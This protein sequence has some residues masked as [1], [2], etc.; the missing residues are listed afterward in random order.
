MTRPNH[1]EASWPGL[2]AAAFAL[3]IVNLWP[4]ALRADP[5]DVFP[6][7]DL[8]TGLAASS[9]S[10]PEEF[11]PLDGS[12]VFV[13][14]DIAHGTELWITDGTAPGTVLLKDIYPGFR[15]SMASDLTAF[16][17][18]VYFSAWDPSFGIELWSTDG[19]SEGTQIVADLWPGALGFSYPRDLTVAGD[20]LF[21]TATTEATGLEL[22]KLSSGGVPEL[23]ID[24]RPGEE[25]SNAK[26]LIAAGSL[27]AFSAFTPATGWELVVSDGTAIGTEIYD[28]EP[29]MASSQP[30]P[31]GADDDQLIFFSAETPA[32]GRELWRLVPG[33]GFLCR[34]MDGVTGTGSSNPKYAVMLDNTLF[35]AADSDG[36]PGIWRSGG[37][38]EATLI[39][40]LDAR[41]LIVAW[42]EVLFEVDGDLWK[43]NGTLAGTEMLASPDIDLIRNGS[44][45]N[46]VAFQP[47]AGE[48]WF[49][50]A[51][52]VWKTDG[53]AAN[54]QLRFS[55][56][57]CSSV[58]WFQVGADGLYLSRDDGFVD[59][60]PWR[61]KTS[62]FSLLADINRNI[63]HSQPRE[64]TV[65]EEQI[66]FTA[67]TDAA[68]RELLAWDGVAA[69][70]WVLE[71]LQPGTN[72]STPQDLM[73]AGDR[74]FYTANDPIVGSEL[75]ILEEPFLASSL[76]VD[77]DSGQPRPLGVL[78]G[79]LFFVADDDDNVDQLWTTP[80]TGATQ[81]S[82]FPPGSS[83]GVTRFVPA[84]VSNGEIYFTADDGVHGQE[85]WRS[86]GLTVGLVHDLNPGPT[87]STPAN[88][89]DHQG[90]L[91]LQ[92]QAPNQGL[93]NTDGTVQNTQLLASNSLGY[94][95]SLGSQFLYVGREDATGLELWT[96]DGTPGG[97]TLVADISAGGESSIFRFGEYWR[98]VIGNTVYFQ[99][100]TLAS[101]VEL[102]ASDGTPG[103]TRLVRDIAPGVIA[104]E[105]FFF[106]PLPNGDMVFSAWTE[107]H[108]RELWR[109]DGTSSGTHRVSDIAPGPESSDPLYLTVYQDWV[110]FEASSGIAGRETWAYDWT[111]SPV[112]FGDGFESGGT[113][114]WS[115]P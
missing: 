11:T 79:D 84:A 46:Y 9:P 85:L 12:T 42:P 72:D 59:D 103:G 28:V 80:G 63:G 31:L 62:S 17:G 23:V 19:T 78:G 83:N 61:I 21:F 89:V 51:G 77:L 102:W 34:E 36:G 88:L 47:F 4:G 81:I 53:T 24:L 109:S 27:V 41:G 115:A 26:D 35:F 95:F 7:G 20:T 60:E 108:G 52:G 29:G 18:R 33:P 86:D 54:T 70:P 13:A 8:F 16:A 49:F 104:S 22:W 67:T 6:L 100:N 101:G 14:Q 66:Y 96:T 1:L 110:V 30:L 50:A 15:D 99:A 5:D 91:Y 90:L 69:I 32:F 64:F 38:C 2:R 94:G 43:T 10:N 65:V 92:A 37:Y 68:G 106:T 105:P 87:S 25:G 71:D 48:Y 57:D 76:V 75:R 113:A 107:G 74:L 58:E 112:I 55:C 97:E 44:F 40:N 3:V 98:A 56:T 39:A 111:G 93:W 45:I 114:A 73:R 82:S